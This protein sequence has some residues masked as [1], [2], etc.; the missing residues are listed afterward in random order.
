MLAV[1]FVRYM[2]E[3]LHE[4]PGMPSLSERQSCLATAWLWGMEGCLV[5]TDS[6][7]PITVLLVHRND[8]ARAG[9][10]TLLAGDPRFTIVG[11]TATDGVSLARRLRPHLIIVDPR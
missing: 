5:S 2:Q 6:G 8:L 1:P 9:L 7:V 11:E 3:R 4:H 10:A